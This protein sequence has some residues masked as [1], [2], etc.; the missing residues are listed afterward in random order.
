[1]QVFSTNAA[2]TDTI[3]HSLDTLTLD[4][5]KLTLPQI[6]SIQHATATKLR[7]RENVVAYQASKAT[8]KEKA[9][10][11]VIKH[12]QEDLEVKAQK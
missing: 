2:E 8:R 11:Q 12:Q 10:K 1:M 3:F 4:F 9:H 7:I 6:Y 5:S